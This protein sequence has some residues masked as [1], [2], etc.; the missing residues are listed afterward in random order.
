MYDKTIK[1][2]DVQARISPEDDQEIG[3]KHARKNKNIVISM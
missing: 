2:T 3:S 1:V